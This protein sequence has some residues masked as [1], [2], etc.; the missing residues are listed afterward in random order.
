MKIALAQINCTLGD[1]AGNSARIIS[2]S[3]RAKQAGASLLL[4]PEMSLCGY[5]PEDLLLRDG[6]YQA[7]KSALHEL[8]KKI[9]LR[10]RVYCSNVIF[11][12]CSI[13][14]IF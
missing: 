3:E 2:Y 12:R 4:T 1:L 6:F 9:N 8:A 14:P 11:L 5:Q 10:I 7:C 13:I